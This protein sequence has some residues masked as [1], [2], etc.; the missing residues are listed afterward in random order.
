MNKLNFFDYITDFLDKTA[1]WQPDTPVEKY[2]GL[3]PDK[4]QPSEEIQ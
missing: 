1:T 2:R 3:L 4:W